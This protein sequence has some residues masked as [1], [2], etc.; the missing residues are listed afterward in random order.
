MDSGSRYKTWVCNAKISDHMSVI[1][2]MENVKD[3]VQYPFKFN[4]VW[5]DDPDFV[6]LFRSNWNG[7]LGTESLNPME[8]LVKISSY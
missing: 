4:F 2:H 1:L 3:H 5:L 6:D 8:Y 7:L